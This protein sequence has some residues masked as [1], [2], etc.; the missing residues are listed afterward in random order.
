MGVR[1]ISNRIPELAAQM[2]ALKGISLTFGYQGAT[3]QEKYATGITVATNAAVQE[4]GTD[5][6]PQRP[7]LRR[8]TEEHADAIEAIMA[9]ALADVA[10]LRKDA[11]EAMLDAANQIHG[12]FLETLDTTPAWATPNAPVTID[13]KGHDHPLMGGAPPDDGPVRKLRENLT[14]AIRRNGSIVAEGR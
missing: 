12:L 5:T 1:V 9:D 7:F 4:F 10:N 8:T 11:V 14:W 13:R 3:G 2:Q 6:I